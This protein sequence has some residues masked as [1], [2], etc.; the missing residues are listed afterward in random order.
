[1][2][3]AL[4]NSELYQYI[5]QKKF[6]SI[7]VLKSHIQEMPLPILSTKNYEII[8]QLFDEVVIGKKTKE[9]LDS[10]IFNLLT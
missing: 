1:M 4:F 10:Y 6:N 7:K 2:I 3:A 9:E 8:E 5:F